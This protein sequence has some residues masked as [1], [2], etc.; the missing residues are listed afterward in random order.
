MLPLIQYTHIDLFNNNSTCIATQ[1]LLFGDDLVDWYDVISKVYLLFNKCSKHFPPSL[2]TNRFN[3]YFCVNSSKIISQHRLKDSV[4][5][6][7]Y[8]D[9]ESYQESCSLSNAQHRFKCTDQNKNIACFSHSIIGNRVDDCLEKSDEDVLNEK[10]SSKTK[11]SIQTMCDS[12]TELLPVLIDG[13]NETDETECSHFPCNN[14]YTRCDGIWNCP[15]G[16]DE[17]NCEWPPLCPSFHHMCI[18]KLTSNLTC[19]SIEHVNNGIVDCFGSFDER[20]F[21]RENAASAP[22]IY[23][24]ENT[25]KCISATAAC[26]PFFPCEPSNGLPKFCSKLPLGALH[27]PD[28]TNYSY[29]E[30]MLC[31]FHGKGKRTILHFSLAVNRSSQWVLGSSKL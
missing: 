11:V 27:C 23:H 31:L 2:L 3:L 21:C 9:D 24:C 10:Q 30:H 5:D 25:N 6:C 16:A 22:L 20:Q 17:V 18:S 4:D 1:D 28:K 7:L 8:G 26:D 12:F 14:T 13:K 29:L 15:D 19:L